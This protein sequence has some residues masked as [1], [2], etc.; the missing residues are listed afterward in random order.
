MFEKSL[1][2]KIFF[3]IV[4]NYLKSERNCGKWPILAH[5]VGNFLVTAEQLRLRGKRIESGMRGGVA[6][7]APGKR[8]SEEGG[9][10]SK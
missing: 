7:V 10:G 8:V 6:P 5:V 9:K 4:E 1:G 3:K 2:L